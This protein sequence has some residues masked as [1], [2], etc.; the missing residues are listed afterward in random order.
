[1]RALVSALTLSLLVLG[2]ADPVP[3]DVITDWN[4]RA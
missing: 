3:G 2:L 1:M 4:E